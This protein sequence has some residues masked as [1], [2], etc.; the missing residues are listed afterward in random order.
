MG[1]LNSVL[2]WGILNGDFKWD[3]ERGF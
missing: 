3:I 2:E 1:I